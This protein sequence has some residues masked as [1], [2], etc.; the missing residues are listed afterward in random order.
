MKIHRNILVPCN[1][2]LCC[3]L[4]GLIFPFMSKLYNSFCPT[5]PGVGDMLMM[6]GIRFIGTGLLL[7]LITE[8]MG[9]HPF[10]IARDRKLLRKAALFGLLETSV[11]YALLYFS[12]LWLTGD[13]GSLL[14]TTNAFF[15]VLLAHFFCKNDRL[16]VRKVLGCISGILG[17]II[18]LGGSGETGTFEGDILMLGAALSF[19]A[20]NILCQRVSQEIEPVTLT[21]WQM[22]FGGTVLLLCGVLTG[23]DLSAGKSDAWMWMAF[24][25]FLSAAP[26]SI[27]SWLLSQNNVSSVGIYTCLVPVIGVLC[28][29][30]M[31]GTPIEAKVLIS[32]LFVSAGVVIINFTLHPKHPT[33]KP[34]QPL[35]KHRPSNC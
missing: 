24:F 7:L 14:N 9:K 21:G 15:S 35:R 8:V 10:R 26:F 32:L 23:G 28:T 12:M 2:V 17:T 18:L 30:L 33:P 1:A 4:W 29:A 16:T 31:N 6:A 34:G 22:L 20:A 11:Q 25:I 5:G 27:W 13:R 3:A 19:A